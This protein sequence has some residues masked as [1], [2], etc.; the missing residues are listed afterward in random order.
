MI[1]TNDFL[2][3]N[4]EKKVRKEIKKQI[5][6][7][8][9]GFVDTFIDLGKAKNWVFAGMELKR[10]DVINT[11]TNLIMDNI[12]NNRVA[13]ATTARLMVVFTRELDFVDIDFYACID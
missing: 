8:Y 10:K 4:S 11:L 13:Y 9:R 12:Y 5:K 1:L 6:Q 2:L 7:D 3:Y